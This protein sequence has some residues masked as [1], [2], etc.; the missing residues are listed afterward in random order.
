MF[1]G[2]FLPTPITYGWLTDDAMLGRWTNQPNH[3]HDFL[4][5][6]ISHGFPRHFL[7]SVDCVVIS[8]KQHGFPIKSREY[9]LSTLFF[10]AE[11]FTTGMAAY[12]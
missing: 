3:P 9:N 11:R 10:V 12:I 2:V 6:S 5:C 1:F 4:L 8:L 7:V